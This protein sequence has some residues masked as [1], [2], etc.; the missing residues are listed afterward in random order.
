MSE[1]TPAERQRIAEE[2]MGWKLITHPYC[3]G[4]FMY[5]DAAGKYQRF[6]DGFRP[7]TDWGQCG[8]C[9]DE[10]AH[11]GRVLIFQVNPHGASSEVWA[12]YPRQDS[13]ESETGPLAICRAILAWLDSRKEK[14]P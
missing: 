11:Q 10:V 4:L 5:V 9:I 1:L 3:P 12:D 2:L 6:Q 8:M 14:T 13:R 7:D